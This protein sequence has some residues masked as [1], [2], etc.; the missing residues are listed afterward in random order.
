LA[1]GEQGRHNHATKEEGNHMK[2]EIK[3]GHLIISIPVNEP[4][5]RSKSGKSLIVA[6]TNGNQKTGIIVQG[7][8]V[9]L[10]VN[11]YIPNQE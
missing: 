4:P 8:A 11:A 2:V 3:D 5:V 7:K 9:V 6:S 1:D 10:G